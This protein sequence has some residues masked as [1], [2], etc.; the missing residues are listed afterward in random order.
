MG[1]RYFIFDMDETLAELYSVYYFIA[2]LRL[3]ETLERVNKDEANNIPE[4]LNTSLNKAYNKSS[5][6]K[7][8][9]AIHYSSSA[10]ILLSGRTS[11][12]LFMCDVH[13]YDVKMIIFRLKIT[14]MRH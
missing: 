14:C 8:I 12:S 1:G 11:S 13:S 5:L 2:S 6:K 10:I 7:L 4:S 3:K 9:L